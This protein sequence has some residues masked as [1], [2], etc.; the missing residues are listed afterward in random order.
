MVVETIFFSASPIRANPMGE[1][2]VT[3]SASF[4]TNGS[5]LQIVTSDRVIINWQ[6]FSIGSGELTRL[7][8]PSS[9][10]AALNRVVS[11]NLSS[12]L[13]NLEANGQVYLINPNGILIGSGARINVGTF[14]AST[15]DIA[16]AEFMGGGDLSFSGASTAAIENFGTI[17]AVGGDVF[18]ITN[19]IENI[20]AI[21][22][23]DGV[24]GLAAG[25][26]VLLVQA[27]NERLIV[28]PS[29][30][31][32]TSF[33]DVGIANTG[34]IEAATA[35]LKAAGGNV[36]ALAINN[37][38]V[39]NA[40]GSL[41]KGGEVYLV[42]NGGNIE[43]YGTITA[44]NVNGNGG[45]ALISAGHNDESPAMALNY[46]T[47]DA[48]GNGTGSQGGSVRILGDYVGLFKGS[49]V[50]VTGDMG[51]GEALIGG[52][53]QG[54]NPDIQN[55]LVTY[56]DQDAQIKADALSSG[57]G[58]KVIV[59]ADGTTR[60]YGDAS[61]RG[62][63]EDGNGG[64]IEVSGHRHLSFQGKADLEAVNGVGG[65]LLLDPANITVSTGAD[66]NTAG[67]N[68]AS[69]LTETFAED[70][71][72]DS[73]FDVTAT[74]G[75]F[76]GVAAGSTIELQATSNVTVSNAFN[77]ATATGA[78][79]VSLVLR[80]GNN[81]SISAAV[82]ASGTGTL[83]LSADDNTPG[84]AGNINTNASG[85]LTTANQP[86]SLTA[87][88]LG[89]NSSSTINSGS[90]AITINPS[91][92]STVGLGI[93]AG[94]MNITDAEL[95]TFTTS[96]TLTIGGS[97]ATTI[98]MSTVSVP[99]SI[100]TLSL[101]AGNAS[102]AITFSG[103]ASSVANAL[104]LTSVGAITQSVALTITGTTTVNA[105][106]NAL[107]LTTAGNDFIGA[108]SLNNSGANNIDITDTN[109]LNLGVSSVG[110]T[111]TARAAGGDLTLSGKVTAN[112]L[113]LVG[114]HF[115]NNAG[116][117]AISSDRFLI[118][119]TDPSTD[120][121]GG[122]SFDFRE[123]NV[124]YPTGSKYAAG[125][126]FLHSTSPTFGS[127]PV[128]VLVDQ[129]SAVSD[130]YLTEQDLLFHSS[131]NITPPIPPTPELTKTNQ[132]Y[133]GRILASASGFEFFS[134]GKKSFK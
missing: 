47:I 10:S 104:V 30:V 15:L 81:V 82:T 17:N 116:S 1:S 5:T 134:K 93:G 126:G 92:S 37:E 55:A 114:N 76:A 45:D 79:N 16:D 63:S 49:W 35:E 65:R 44:S 59:W 23:A 123:F 121:T 85:S 24:V 103:G 38:G 133:Q 70:S 4:E 66:T 69:D 52:D 101:N 108:V 34:I 46:G 40:T 6:D 107:T 118:Y 86:I 39:I 50:D 94:T 131:A 57:D 20:G 58:G 26:E 32:G 129:F 9:S 13:G 122:L 132:K 124:N 77:L 72:L 119:S 36:Y 48:S 74:T 60:F 120:Q 29:T 102:G 21:S 106:A 14:T 73:V 100:G 112:A 83:T 84:G 25:Q 41:Y 110:G 51:G 115:I 12:I 33:T 53:Y 54:K 56:V 127:D 90:G 8:Q 128:T 2:V 87:V 11:G 98:T 68:A 18:L 125:K 130:R 99:A 97:N 43:N 117:S 19:K 78:A 71:G 89:L 22:A 88:S 27:G 80:A 91:L 95:D 28:K 111:L 62:G 64:L 61:A 42:A 67:F 31:Y 75:S 3:G 109:A 7:I 113:T 105:G 96:G